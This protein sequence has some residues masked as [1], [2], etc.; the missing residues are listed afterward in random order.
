MLFHMLRWEIGDAAFDKTMR[1]FIK[2]YAGKPATADNLRKVAEQQSGQQLSG[3]FTQWLDSTGA[4]E[5]KNKYTVYRTAK[6]FRIVGQINQDLD[7]FRMPVE[8]K[9]DTDGPSE[10]KRI[11]VVGTD[12]AYSVDTFGKPRRITIDPNDWVL[13]NSPDLKLRTAIL[14]GSQLVKEGDLAE[15]LV[16]YKNA[17]DTN[18]QSSLAHFRIAEVYFL[19]HNYQAAATNIASRSTATGTRAGLR[20]GA[21]FSLAKF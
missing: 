11:E 7:L 13:K 2:Q 17:L 15:A 10:M 16:Q 18:H 5:F 6:G 19:Q 14:R 4:P 21:I 20:F 12:S 8:L 1:E 3:F 9:V